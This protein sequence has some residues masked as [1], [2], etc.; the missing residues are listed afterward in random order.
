MYHVNTHVCSFFYV[1]PVKAVLS[2]ILFFSRTPSWH[3][4][5]ILFH[6]RLLLLA[7]R[8]SCLMSAFAPSCRSAEA[9]P[10]RPR[11]VSI[12]NTVLETSEFLHTR[13]YRFPTTRRFPGK[14]PEIAFFSSSQI[15][16]GISGNLDQG[17]GLRG[18][19]GGSDFF[20]STHHTIR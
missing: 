10:L 19:E 13:L 17:Q 16:R 5:P 4:R 15:S 8:R 6:H 2:I 12:R 14:F 1:S 3:L 18:V 20:D 7:A 11:A 9:K